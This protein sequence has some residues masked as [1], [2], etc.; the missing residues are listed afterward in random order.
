MIKNNKQIGIKTVTDF[1]NYILI[2]PNPAGDHLAI[3]INK[4]TMSCF[5]EI[6]NPLGE[7]VYRGDLAKENSTVDLQTIKNGLYYLKIAGDQKI[8]YSKKLIIQH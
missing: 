1:N 3:Q 4:N 7:V 8:L 2:Y 6:T 5:L